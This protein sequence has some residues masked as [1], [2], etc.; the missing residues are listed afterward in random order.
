MSNDG[1]AHVGLSVTMSCCPQR[2]EATG[3]RSKNYEA[4]VTE[5]EG[6]GFWAP[7]VGLE[8]VPARYANTAPGTH[9]ELVSRMIERMGRDSALEFDMLAQTYALMRASGVP[10]ADEP[11]HFDALARAI[12]PDFATEYA[13]SVE[14]KVQA[15]TAARQSTF[16]RVNVRMQRGEPLVTGAELNA[17]VESG[18]ADAVLAGLDPSLLGALEKQLGALDADALPDGDLGKALA[19]AVKRTKR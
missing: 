7:K 5:V 14:R 8:H 6:A 13:K 9:D 3:I 18:G 11:G 1:D 4:I 19:S 10:D 12:D 16:D 17:F 15:E 2:P